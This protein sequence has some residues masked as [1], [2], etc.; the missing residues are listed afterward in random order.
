MENLSYDDVF[1]KTQDLISEKNYD[2][3]FSLNKEY[4]EQN[5]IDSQ[6]TLGFLYMNGLGVSKDF[7]KSERWLLK[8]KDNGSREAI[9]YLGAL[10]M[11]KNNNKKALEYFITA[12]NKGYVPAICRS[13]LFYK[14]G[15]ATKKDINSAYKYLNQASEL[16]NYRAKKEIALIYLSG[17]KGTLNRFKSIIMLINTIYTALKESYTNSNSIN[18]RY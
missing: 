5:Y 14:D 2:E 18:F 13:G 8:S 3:A 6:T 7:E 10:E 9:Y 15:I 17:Y 16:G 11:H 1:N 4:A 12:A